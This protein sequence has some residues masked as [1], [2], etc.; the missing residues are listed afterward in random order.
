MSRGLYATSTYCFFIIHPF[1]IIDLAS[2]LPYSIELVCNDSS[3]DLSVIR[4]ARVLHIIP[5]V[6]I[7]RY[8]KPL[9]VMYKAL[10]ESLDIL[11]MELV[12]ISVV[13]KLSFAFIYYAERDNWDPTRE[14][15]IR[16]ISKRPG[17]WSLYCK[18]I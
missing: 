17:N 7:S 10:L 4:V 9:L 14:Q 13:M 15:W 6:K 8:A 12:Y 5:I 2:I 18:T 16:C 11:Y 3:I 1:K